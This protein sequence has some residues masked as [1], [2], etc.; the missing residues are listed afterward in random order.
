MLNLTDISGQSNRFFLL[1]FAIKGG[2]DIN[3]TLL[4]DTFDS[5]IDETQWEFHPY[6][7][8]EA[9]ACGNTDSAIYWANTR[10][11]QIRGG[12]I[13][14]RQLI[15]DTD[16]MVQFKVN[17]SLNLDVLLLNK[18]FPHVCLMH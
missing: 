6:S 9:H 15:I 11:Y 2:S 13:T 1:S 14:T 16:Y 7:S 18:M 8:V 5:A 17:D 4:I 12:Y 3:P 10:G